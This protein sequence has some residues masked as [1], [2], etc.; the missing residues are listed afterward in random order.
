MKIVEVG[1]NKHFRKEFLEFPVRLYNRNPYWIRPLD[2]DIE[3]IFDPTKN[4]LH[5]NNNCIRW[6]ALNE[7]GDT[8]A[9]VAAFVNPNTVIYSNDQPTGGI[10]FFECIND[11]QVAFALF[12]TC[13]AW[14]KARGMEAMDGPV[15][16]GERDN[17]WGLLVD[18][19]DA[20][21]TWSM[22]YHHDY[23]RTFFE[24]Y[25]FQD[26]FRQYTFLLPL[27][28]KEARKV[29][30]PALFEIATRV[31][32]SPGYDFRH[33]NKKELSK[34]AQDFRTI[35]NLA[36]SKNMAA[37]EMTAERAEAIMRQ[38][39]PILVEELMWFGYHNNKP[40]AFFIMIPELNQI[41]KHLNGKLDIIG[42]LKWVYHR[43]MKTN[44]KARGVIF[45]VIPEY[46][47][48]GIESAIALAFS[49]ACWKPGYQ[50]TTLELNWIADFNPKML[51]VTQLLGA[52]K[53]KTYITYRYL[54]DHTRAFKRHPVI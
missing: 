31:Y 27:E 53:F 25:G 1:N 30:R 37:G 8:I 5:E 40:I 21:P 52:R 19:Y 51:K 23:Y 44:H 41:I 26:Y 45:G 35:Y 34:F 32:N 46:Q 22:F 54:F 2:N 13:K 16:F 39:K 11:K 49:R 50:Y 17:W 48:R 36:W 10:G 9:R 14:L 7:N 6:L 33:I 4:P 38:M 3:R 24:E 29:V 20:E 12:D 18:P 43:L 28:E 42:K 47:G 15:N